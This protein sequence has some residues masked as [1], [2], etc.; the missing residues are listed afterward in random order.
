MKLTKIRTEYMN[1]DII[2][3]GSVYGSTVYNMK[4]QLIDI[5]PEDYPDQDTKDLIEEHVTNELIESALNP[6]LRF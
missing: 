6:E 3:K 1:Y 2:A 5:T 4:Y